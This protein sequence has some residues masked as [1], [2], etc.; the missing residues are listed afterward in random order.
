[1]SYKATYV[2]WQILYFSAGSENMC[3]DRAKKYA[4]EVLCY[5]TAPVEALTGQSRNILLKGLW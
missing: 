5:Y 3:S 2:K 1:M 4:Y